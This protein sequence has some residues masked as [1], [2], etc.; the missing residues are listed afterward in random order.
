MVRKNR[1]GLRNLRRGAGVLKGL[2][3]AAHLPGRL[4]IS[5]TLCVLQCEKHKGGYQNENDF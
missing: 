1:R 2:A 3:G 4:R 5:L